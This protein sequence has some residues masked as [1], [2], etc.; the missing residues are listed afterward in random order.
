MRPA[1]CVDHKKGVVIPPH[2]RFCEA[3]LGCKE[4]F[5]RCNRSI[6]KAVRD[7]ATQKEMKAVLVDQCHMGFHIITC[8]VIT[9]DKFHGAIFA[10]GFLLDSAKAERGTLLPE[11]A[12]KEGLS[13]VTPDD[14][15]AAVPTLSAKDMDY[16]KD[17]LET[18]V[19]EIVE[20]S[21]T[22]DQKEARI[23][24]LNRELGGRYQF[25]NIVGKS[26]A[27]QRLFACSRR[28]STARARCSSTARTA[29]ARS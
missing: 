3:S 8:P 18:T 20:F 11:N 12:K 25:G 24:Q 16:F 10:C 9:E 21:R 19:E 14:A 1:S 4:G 26:V 23:A 27:M 22:V 29:P 15:Y 6:E 7:L 5:A 17:L 2:S 13:I 28:S